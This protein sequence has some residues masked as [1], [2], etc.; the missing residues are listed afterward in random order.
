MQTLN[1]PLEVGIRQLALLDSAFPRALDLATLASLDHAVLHSAD[2][3]GPASLHPGVPN[4][5][6]EQVVKRE[7]IE[8]GLQVMIRAGLVGVRI[9]ADGIL[10]AATE[11][12]NPF[13]GLLEARYLR[14]LRER[15]D[16]VVGRYASESRS[17]HD[18]RA[19]QRAQHDATAQDSL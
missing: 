11:R 10:Y 7:F 6:A 18:N 12:A 17:E 13:L 5:R 3:G 2:L 1:G 4:Y 9:S 15:A 14:D 8:H 19:H 16:W